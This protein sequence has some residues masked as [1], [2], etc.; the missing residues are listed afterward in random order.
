MPGVHGGGIREAHLLGACEERHSTGKGERSR[1]ERSRKGEGQAEPALPHVS[2]HLQGVGKQIWQARP[3]ATQRERRAQRT[4]HRR[5]RPRGETTRGMADYQ[6]DSHKR[7]IHRHLPLSIRHR[8]GSRLETRVQ[9]QRRNRRHRRQPAVALPATMHP[10][11]RGMQGRSTRLVLSVEG[12][13]TL[14]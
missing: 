3:M 2:S 8:L 14:Y 9:G 7:R 13:Y 1:Q 10:I 11:R 4:I 5:Y 6:G 12:G